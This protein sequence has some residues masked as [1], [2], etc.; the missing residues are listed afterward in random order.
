MLGTD[1]TFPLCVATSSTLPADT[2]PTRS[3][4]RG[5]WPSTVLTTSCPRVLP[6]L[7]SIPT[8]LLMPLRALFLNSGARVPPTHH[9]FSSR[10]SSHCYKS[11]SAR[12]ALLRIVR[13][14]ALGASESNPLHSHSSKLF[15]APKKLNPF[16][17]KQI[18]T[19]SPKHP[20]RGVPQPLRTSAAGQ[21][22]HPLFSWSYKLLFRE[23]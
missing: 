10:L 6:L 17:I 12:S 1:A 19:L 4:N 23:P 22:A 18:R 9:H 16:G 11:P 21:F 2:S 3:K 5:H 15:V 8:S 7:S 20:G 13:I 14:S